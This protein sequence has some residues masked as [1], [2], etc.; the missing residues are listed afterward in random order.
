MFGTKRDIV[1][2][3]DIGFLPEAAVSG[4]V[5]LQ[6]D[7]N[8]FLTFNAVRMTEDDKRADAGTAVIE[9]EHCSLTKF[10]YPNDE[11]LGGHPLAKRGL[12]WYGVF[13]VEKSSWIAEKT[14]QNRVN[15]PNTT[16]DTQSRHFIFTFHDSTFECLA[17]DLRAKLDDR[18]YHAIVS[19]LT[20]RLT[21]N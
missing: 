21:N 9:F 3:L 13:E 4:P 5:L 18:P 8:A 7:F 10:G 1:R 6:N 2:P 15:F 20:G 11:A 19:E 17:W 16:E 12:K 14:K